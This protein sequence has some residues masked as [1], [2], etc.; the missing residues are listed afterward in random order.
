MSLK[1]F[2]LVI[3]IIVFMKMTVGD[4]NSASPKGGTSPRQIDNVIL[5]QRTLAYMPS[6]ILGK[7][8][9]LN[10]SLNNEEKFLLAEIGNI[11]TENLILDRK[12]EFVE[13]R[14]YRNFGV[15]GSR[16]Q[17]LFKNLRPGEEVRLASTTLN[18]N[19]PISINTLISND[20]NNKI[21]LLKV[22]QTLLHEIGRKVRAE[23]FGLPQTQQ[24]EDAKM[25]IV[26]R[27]AA[28]L[29][30][31]LEKDYQEIELS[32]TEK[33]L[34]LNSSTQMEMPTLGLDVESREY[35]KAKNQL[36][37][38]KIR[39]GREILIFYQD[40]NGFTYVPTLKPALM[41]GLSTLA[42]VNDKEGIFAGSSVNIEQ[43]LVDRALGQ[44]PFVRFIMGLTQR[45]YRKEDVT[46]KIKKLEDDKEVEVDEKTGETT[47]YSL[48]A[49]NK[50]DLAVGEADDLV[51]VRV[52]V[53]LNFTLGDAPEISR[54]EVLDREP[55]IQ[56][57]D[58]IWQD[59]GPVRVGL[60]TIDVPNDRA[61][62][63][64]TSDLRAY[65]WARMETGL[66]RIEVTRMIPEG[67]Q[68]KVEFKIPSAEGTTQA[69]FVEEV[70]L[71][72]KSR[73]LVL[74]LPE[75][76]VIKNPKLGMNPLGL[77]SFEH[78]NSTGWNQLKIEKQTK[79]NTPKE[80]DISKLQQLPGSIHVESGTQKMKMK[81]QSSST[82]H[83]IYFYIRSAFLSHDPMVRA[84]MGQ[85]NNIPMLG[86]VLFKQNPELNY[87]SASLLQ[88]VDNVVH[89]PASQLK[90]S[91]VGDEL[92]VE[93]ELAMGAL[94]DRGPNTY[95]TGLRYVGK[96][97]AVNQRM[98]RWRVSDLR[99]PL[100]V[101]SGT[102]A[103][104]KSCGDYFKNKQ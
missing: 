24:F 31:E 5:F 40:Q 12:E 2:K 83:E 69:F 18:L 68:L 23:K 77:R 98:E 14:N 88:L 57:K 95:D 53:G 35:A 99:H 75:T 27:I 91:L 72:N 76:L 13:P 45:V 90:Q 41:G 28:K 21:S 60:F 78:F 87:R 84:A 61:R 32:P 19:E 56:I 89:I 50:K 10:N 30:R 97:I 9:R 11:A 16:D 65:L 4:A 58:L 82:L 70:I 37:G 33:L 44:R 104:A 55:L 59:Q 17:S 86:G 34:I 48:S 54:R 80:N 3:S 96:I 26:D 49:L 102:H 38:S 92:T 7:S 103:G 79:E 36:I 52:E 22:V 20:P 51:R 66:A 81:F 71:E 47:V 94:P 39:S 85:L 73:L 8:E 64:V 25:A 63:L 42:S 74:D 101:V 1:S 62:S 29:V 93:F 6:F 67:N 46:K 15:V 43:I 100:F